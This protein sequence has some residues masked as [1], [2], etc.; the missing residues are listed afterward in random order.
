VCVVTTPDRAAELGLAPML[1]LAARPPGRPTA[2]PAARF[3]GDSPICR[4]DLVIG[5]CRS[6]IIL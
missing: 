2:R 1:R 6:P 3:T 4:I 5:S